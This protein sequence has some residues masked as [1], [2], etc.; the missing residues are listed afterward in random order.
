MYTSRT[1]DVKSIAWQGHL[2]TPTYEVTLAVMI[3]EP[4]TFLH[5]ST[6]SWFMNQSLFKFFNQI[7][8]HILWTTIH[9][10]NIFFSKGTLG[11][12][13][14]RELINIYVKRKTWIYSSVKNKRMIQLDVKLWIGQWQF[15][16][17]NN[18]E[19]DNKFQLESILLNDRRFDEETN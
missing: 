8:S 18:R 16:K 2:L 10:S 5:V 3:E 7:H 6:F 9:F 14:K 4:S 19:Q 1:Y 17:L 11:K 12:W 15:R 13:L